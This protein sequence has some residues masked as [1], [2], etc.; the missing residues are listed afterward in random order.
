MKIITINKDDCI[1]CNLCLNSCPLFILKKEPEG[2]MITDIDNCD[3]CG[4]CI[5]S[6]PTE[7]I[8]LEEEE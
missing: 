8:T 1:N 3:T 5:E 7:A 4:E 2:I 6:C